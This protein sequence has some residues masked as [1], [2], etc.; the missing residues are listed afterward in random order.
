MG[1]GLSPPWYLLPDFRQMG[2]AF[3]DVVQDQLGEIRDL[4]LCQRLAFGDAVP[5]GDT[6]PAA[7]GGRVLG[8]AQDISLELGLAT[9]TRRLRWSD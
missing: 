3:I 9:V 6:L 2:Q 5:L 7:R 1:R 4:L 8:I